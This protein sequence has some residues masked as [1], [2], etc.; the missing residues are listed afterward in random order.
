MSICICLYTMFAKYTKG[1]LSNSVQCAATRNI[2]ILKPFYVS[3]ISTPTIAFRYLPILSHLRPRP[4]KTHQE[5][6]QENQK[7]RIH[8][9]LPPQYLP[10][11]IAQ[12]ILRHEFYQRGV[13]EE[14][15][16]DGV[17]DAHNEE[18]DFGVGRV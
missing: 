2:Y 6:A 5:R 12:E 14:A 17:H 10:A 1:V 9:S 11:L 13:N 16:R 15:G 7:T 3:D 8:P 4:N 18:A